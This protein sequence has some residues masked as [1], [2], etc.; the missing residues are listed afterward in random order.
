VLQSGS[1]CEQNESSVRGDF[2]VTIPQPD[3]AIEHRT[4]RRGILV[5]AEIAEPF[6]L[7]SRPGIATGELGL[8]ARIR[9]HFKRIRIE[10]GGKIARIRIRLGE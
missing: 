7:H 1:N 6:E 5:Q 8:N 10:I 3:G 9:D 4:S 2:R